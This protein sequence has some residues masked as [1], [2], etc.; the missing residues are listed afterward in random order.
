MNIAL[1]ILLLV[2]GGLSFW[3]LTESTVK[4]YIKTVCIATFCLFT[5]VFWTTIHTFLGW[6]ANE[7]DMPE[8]VLIH[9]V[10]IKEPNKFKEFTGAIYILAE[11]AEKETSVVRRF[12]GYGKDR[13]E[14][15]LY[16]LKYNRNLHEQ[17]RKTLIPKLRSGR[18]VYGKLSKDKKPPGKG[19]N[20]GDGKDKKGD[21]SESQEQEWHFHELLP[22]EIHSKP[23][24]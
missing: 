23:E 6:P 20:K 9:W 2:F 21:G 13:I 1:P 4:W 18:P 24:R 3:I 17:L 11:S 16:Q 15:R 12:F 5:I 22:S 7:S 14:P 19:G 8:K 10:I